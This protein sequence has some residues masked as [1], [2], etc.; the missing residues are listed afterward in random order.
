MH[1]LY[2]Q[3]ILFVVV[4]VDDVCVVC[5][6]CTHENFYIVMVF[7][8]CP[9]TRLNFHFHQMKRIK[10]VTLNKHPAHNVGARNVHTVI[11]LTLHCFVNRIYIHISIGM[12]T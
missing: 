5:I 4:F 8:N 12:S 2:L 11:N 1:I 6:A 7:L 10:K 3:F 9:K